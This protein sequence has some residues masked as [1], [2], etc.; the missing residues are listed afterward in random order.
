MSERTTEGE[1]G[2][3]SATVEDTEA[4]ISLWVAACAARDGELVDGIDERARPKFE[5]VERWIV[6]EQA[7]TGIIGFALA[8]KPGTVPPTDL[9]DAPVVALLAVAPDTQRS[10]LGGALLSALEADLGQLGHGRCLLHVLVENHIAVR[11]YESHGWRSLGEPYPHSLLRRPAQTY[12]LDL[13]REES[14]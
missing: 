11:L 7:A 14:R 5:Q 10:G 4:C 6:A 1:V 9:R 2:F 8:T 12:V 13:G 3:R